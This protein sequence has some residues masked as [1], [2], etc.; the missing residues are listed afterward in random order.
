MGVK[1]DKAVSY[2][3][4]IAKDNRHGYSQ[5][6]RFG[7]PGTWSDFD[8]SSLVISAYEDAG[9]PVKT[10]GASYTG[11]MY[12]VFRNCGFIDVTNKV[13]LYTGSGLQK[14][15]VLLNH[16]NHTAMMIDSKNLVQASIDEN[17]NIMGGRVGDQ[18]G[19]EIATRSYYNYPWNCVLRYNEPATKTNT[20]KTTNKTTTTKAKTTTTTKTYTYVVKSGDN[21]T[22]I[23][24][25]YGT[26]AAKIASD[27]KLSNPNLL[28]VGQKL[29]IKVAVK[30]TSTT[31]KTASIKNGQKLSLKNVKVYASATAKNYSNILT[32]TYYVYNN[33]IVNNRVRI[34]IK[35]SYVNKMPIANYVSGWINKSDIK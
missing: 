15:D 6:S 21:L 16:V 10:K 18:T 13:N 22:N 25:K 23:A 35:S 27:N 2:A 32:G 28:K 9:V 29:T 1:I 11:N 19:Y 34:T 31:T 4:D 26:T 14:G 20:T 30:A 3:V 24:K 17:G 8:C 12:N 5:I 33:S 7:K